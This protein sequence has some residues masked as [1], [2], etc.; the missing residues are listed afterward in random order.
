MYFLLISF[1]TVINLITMF[2]ENG[3][4]ELM[5]DKN[6]RMEVY[7]KYKNLNRLGQI[8][9]FIFSILVLPSIVGAFLGMVLAQTIYNA[10]KIKSYLER[11]CYKK[12]DD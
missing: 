12:E 11:I 5:T 2:S 8:V 4:L 7:K 3:M 1:I 9:L 6:K 10:G